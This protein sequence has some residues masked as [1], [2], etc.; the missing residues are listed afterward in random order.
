M[1]E[2]YLDDREV[3]RAIF[4]RLEGE[5]GK[6]ASGGGLPATIV[7]A[8][9][10]SPTDEGIRP[11]LEVADLA[12]DPDLRTL[13]GRSFRPWLVQVAVVTRSGVSEFSTEEGPRIYADNVRS[14]FPC[15]SPGDPDYDRSRWIQG[16]ADND[17]TVRA[18]G[19]AVGTFYVRAETKIGAT[20][21][22]GGGWRFMVEIRLGS[23]AR[24]VR[25][26]FS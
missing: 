9:P 13:G 24:P 21:R 10:A 19:T 11:R 23:Y 20:F 4:A 12:V 6:P 18:D 8:L 22:E 2:R 17:T 3:I 25:R 14:L 16:V 15:L 26:A 1:T 5:A 7:Y